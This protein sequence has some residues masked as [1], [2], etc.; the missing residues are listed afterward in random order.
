MTARIR[1]PV[2]W[3]GGNMIAPRTH[4]YF[5][6]PVTDAIGS[7]IAAAIAA[8]GPLPVRRLRSRWSRGRARFARSEIVCLKWWLRSRGFTE[9]EDFRVTRMDQCN[10][11]LLFS[12]MLV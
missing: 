6:R 9:D 11:Q 3:H 4:V 2:K 8:P 1:P 10:E 12:G 5:L 7:A